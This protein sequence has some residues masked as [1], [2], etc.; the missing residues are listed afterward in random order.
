MEMKLRNL[1][2]GLC[3]PCSSSLKVTCHVSFCQARPVAVVK[4]SGPRLGNESINERSAVVQG[5]VTLTPESPLRLLVTRQ[6]MASP[7]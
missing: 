5:I 2:Q 6:V 3:G 4:I 1:L 7:S